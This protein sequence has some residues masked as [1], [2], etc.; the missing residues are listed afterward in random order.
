MAEVV[1]RNQIEEKFASSFRTAV[2][3]SMIH[4]ISDTTE[5]VIEEGAGLT[6]NGS[7]RESSYF[8]TVVLLSL[9]T[10]AH[11]L[12]QSMQDVWPKHWKKRRGSRGYRIGSEKPN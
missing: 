2:K 11:D 6:V 8:S 5:L 9:L 7:I 4:Q 12:S 3:T 1:G 10:Y